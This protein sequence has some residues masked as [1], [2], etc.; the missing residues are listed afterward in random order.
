MSKL[1]RKVFTQDAIVDTGF[2]GWLFL[3]PET[4]GFI[5][6]LGDF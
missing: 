4:L 6:Y 2:N 1:N 3:P 5:L